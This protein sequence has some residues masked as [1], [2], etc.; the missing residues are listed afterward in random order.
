MICGLWR[1]G[2]LG[3]AAW[4]ACFA[5]TAWAQDTSTDDD[6]RLPLFR[7]RPHDLV[8]VVGQAEEFRTLPIAFKDRQVPKNPPPTET[9]VLRLLDKPEEAYTVQWRHVESLELYEARVLAEIET[10]VQQ[11]QFELAYEGLTFLRQSFPQ[12]ARLADVTT[13]MLHAQARAELAQKHTRAA[14]SLLLDAASTTPQ[15]TAVIDALAQVTTQLLDECFANHD[16][17]AARKFV[18]TFIAKYPDR[19]EVSKWRE[20]F[21]QQGLAQLELARAAIDDRRLSDARTALQLALRYVP[22]LNEAR[23]VIPKLSGGNSSVAIGVLTPP[24]DSAALEPLARIIDPAARRDNRLLERPLIELTEIGVSGGDY[25]PLIGTLDKSVEGHLRWQLPSDGGLTGYDLSRRLW[26]L[27][28]PRVGASTWSVVLDKL[29][30]EDVFALDMK[31]RWPHLAPEALISGPIGHAADDHTSPLSAII[32]PYQPTHSS[33]NR[34]TYRL[35]AGYTPRAD[36]TPL[37]LNSTWF[38]DASLAT[39]ALLRGDVDIVDS[40]APAEIGEW[41]ERREFAVEPYRVP[42]V[43]CLILRRGHPQLQG[44]SF[45]RGL[46]YAL[47][48]D[49]IL[50]RL[51]LRGQKVP[52]CE[53]AA[54][55]FPRGQSTSDN[56]GY[57][58]DP[59][60]KP[61]VYDPELAATLVAINSAAGDEPAQNTPSAAVTPL[62]FRYPTTPVAQVA[63]KAIAAQWQAVGVDVQLDPLGAGDYGSRDPGDVLYAEL[64]VTEPLVE[65]RVLFG[66]G[67]IAG[68]SPYVT[69][70]LDDLDRATEWSTARRTLQQ[71]HQS[72]HDDAVVIPLWQLT[73]HYVRS[74]RLEGIGEQPLTLFQ[75]VERWQAE[76]RP[77]ADNDPLWPSLGK[78]P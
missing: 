68:G 69:Q 7:Q 66:P 71:I 14:Y 65:A 55:P 34:A 63:A 75:H 51:I 25:R 36:A 8:K 42:S 24:R 16:P 46:I 13:A 27:A 28:D 58:V 20:S 23:E 32:H 15:Q 21:R 47:D 49:G 43:H 77:P 4:L 70:A 11:Q 53:V 62:R 2:V 6:T 52:G 72:V 37:E 5:L 61:R 39:A 56:L 22:D 29:T 10:Y 73:E 48:R 64:V 1:T 60:I 45:R 18:G 30:V 76:L 67:S 35:H 78:K 40:V 31:L 19:P 17:R 54:G 57:A 74:R 50:Q 59:L 41:R 9:F 3:V 26:R 38:S 33:L 12:V 44:R